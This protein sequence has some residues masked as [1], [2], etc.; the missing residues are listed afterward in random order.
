MNKNFL[1]SNINQISNNII[2][3][4]NIFV[5]MKSSFF[6]KRKWKYKYF[7]F[8]L[9]KNIIYLWNPKKLYKFPKKIK[10]IY[11]Y[12]VTLSYD[13]IENVKMHL[14]N[15]TFK[16]TFFKFASENLDYINYFYKY[17]NDYVKI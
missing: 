16:N 7:E 17:F 13:Y 3:S 9:N 6:R 8:D 11:I 2:Y 12:S 4:G 14:L 10:N 5:N 15:F 1:I